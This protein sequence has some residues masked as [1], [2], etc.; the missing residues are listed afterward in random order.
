MG[1][2]GEDGFLLLVRDAR[3]TQRLMRLARLVRDQLSRVVV[4]GTGR[5]P[6][7]LDVG[8]REWLAEA[9]VGLLAAGAELRPS[10]AVAAARAMSR[11]AWSYSS[12]LAGVDAEGNTAEL[13]LAP[14]P[15]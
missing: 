13:P 3:D 1:R 6:G 10:Q 12:R 15:A 2:L 14:S 7:N 4:L 8:G 9:G 11:T 5:D